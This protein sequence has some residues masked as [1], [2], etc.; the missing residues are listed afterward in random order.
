MTNT[1]EDHRNK[2]E[3]AKKATSKIASFRP[4]LTVKADD[5][6]AMPPKMEVLQTGM[7]DA[8]YHGQFMISP[9][10]LQEYVQ[11]FNDDVRPSSSSQGLPI[12]LDHDAGEAAGWMTGLSVAPNEL[13]GWS[14]WADVDWT[15]MGQEKLAN[16][17]YKFFS[18]E[19][20][21]EGYIDP[22]G[23]DEACD[24]VLI[25][26]GLTNRPLFKDLQPIM[27]SDASGKSSGLK[28]EF[29][30]IFIN[31]KEGGMPTLDEVRVKDVDT[32]TDEDRQVLAD[33][34]ADLSA[35]ELAKFSLEGSDESSNEGTDEGDEGQDESQDGDESSET[36]TKK[37]EAT[38]AAD[39]KTTVTISASELDS[40]KAAAAQGVSAHE[41][42]V[43]KEAEDHIKSLCFNER[44]GFKFQADMQDDI[45]DLYVGASDKQKATL[46][47]LFEA[48]QPIKSADDMS[49]KGSSQDQ[50]GAGEAYKALADKTAEIQ[51]ADEKITY[52][53]ALVQ[54]RRENPELA[55]A[56]D[57]EYEAGKPKV[58]E[59]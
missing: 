6:G 11:H 3:T 16:G 7:W 27:A 38:V 41:K 10:D 31:A 26:G 23:D 30:K 47:K 25:G 15:P 8:P 18:P 46:D 45:V 17:Q 5:S 51:K 9:D 36:T 34:K 49:A 14:L 28:Q 40:L 1:K 52:A 24:N 19:F 43:H 58:Q 12:D 4:L 56:F 2:N 59:R 20:C 42:L 50:V 32:L 39:D 33:N 44:T 53:D 22:E 21:P 35:D 55:A 29:N 48:A 54:A 37:E 13:G 57:Q